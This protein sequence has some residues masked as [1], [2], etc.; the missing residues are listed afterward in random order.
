MFIYEMTEEQRYRKKRTCKFCKYRIERNLYRIEENDN[1]MD[2]APVKILY[3]QKLFCSLMDES[4]VL[5][6][7]FCELQDPGN[8]KDMKERTE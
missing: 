8:P 3:K 4:E 7:E 1:P 6:Q 2:S 5:P